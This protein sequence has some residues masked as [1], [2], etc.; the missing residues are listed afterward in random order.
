MGFFFSDT[1][2]RV[3]LE[4]FKKVRAHLASSG[5]S[6]Q[7]I[8]K[9]ENI[10]HGDL[11][12]ANNNQKGIDAKELDQTIKWMKENRHNH[13]LSDKDMKLVEETMKKYI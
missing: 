2:K 10:F 8:D 7:E 3:N 1:P 9:V 11:N 6:H 5:M 4:E 13:N 12:E